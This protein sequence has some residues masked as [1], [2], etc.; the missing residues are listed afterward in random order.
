MKR[1]FT[2]SAKALVEYLWGRA[3]RSPEYEKML[4]TKLENTPGLKSKVAVAEVQ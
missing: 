1:Q 2:N 4:D 3:K